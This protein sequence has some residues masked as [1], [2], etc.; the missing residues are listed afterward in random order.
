[1][2]WFDLPFRTVFSGI[3]IEITLEAIIEIDRKVTNCL[4]EANGSY[5]GPMN[6]FI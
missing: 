3:F 5:E 2:K 4:V 1:M 6:S